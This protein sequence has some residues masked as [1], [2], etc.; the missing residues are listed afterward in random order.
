MSLKAAAEVEELREKVNQLEAAL[1]IAQAQVSNKPHPLLID[2][3]SAAQTTADSPTGPGTTAGDSNS[4][5][6]P[7]AAQSQDEEDV[8]DAFGTLTLGNRGE[9]RFFGQT[10]RTEAPERLKPFVDINIKLPRVT[11]ITVE[12]ACKELDVFCT[13]MTVGEEVLS[14][15]PPMEEALRLCEIYFECSKFLW[16]PLP[17][18]YVYTEIV[19]AI[20][21]QPKPGDDYCHV[22]RKHA[23]ALLFMIFALATLF[24]LNMPPYCSEAHEYLLFARICLRW[25]PPAYDTTL[26]AIQTLL[27]MAQYLEM[28][29]CE[30]AHTGSHKAW[31]EN[32]RAVSMGLSVDVSSCKWRLDDNAA[33]RRG[34]VFWQ[35]FALD[36]WLSF[37]FGRPPSISLTFVD[38]EIPQPEEV[39]AVDGSRWSTGYHVWTWQFTKLM[40]IITTEAFAAKSPT[41][42]KIMELDKRVRDFPDPPCLTEP[43]QPA[44]VAGQNDQV[45]RTM[46]VMGVTLMKEM[47]HM[48]LHRPY[49]SQALK[50][51]PEDPLRHKYGASVMV[52]YRSAW[53]I[54]NAVEQAYKVAPGLTARLSLHWSNTLACAIILSLIITRAPT[55][56]LATSALAELDKLCAL[57]E[58]AA[59]T[60]QIALNNIHVL[61]KLRSQSHAAINNLSPEDAAKVNAELDRLGGKT[62]LIQTIGER[63]ATC[64]HSF[65]GQNALYATM[66]LDPE[67]A[68]FL[69]SVFEAG[70]NPNGVLQ[71]VVAQEPPPPAEDHLSAQTQAF[72][73]GSAADFNFAFMDAS[74]GAGMGATGTG[75]TAGTGDFDWIN[76]FL[77]SAAG[78]AND[79][80]PN[81]AEVDANWQSLVDGLG[82]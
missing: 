20:Y 22:S 8:I 3:Y 55:S 30:A 32:R 41:Y 35:M 72:A 47:T 29:D 64:A 60:S 26:P 69:P 40:A 70:S 57:F 21:Q 58:D 43:A 73:P 44:T 23:M 9:A 50:D 56:A 65:R 53:R 74:M 12:E 51:A 1:A 15:I 45:T 10:S 61:R 31:M 11:R 75:A 16:Y 63:I 28:S 6:S 34:R 80:L 79:S 71:T 14:C 4:S 2:R 52:I 36:S 7:S 25:A 59:S 78:A 37:G 48:N 62:Q 68:M 17:R 49:L 67:K 77:N 81:A 54:I 76:G 66:V 27:Y 82:L 24:D 33:A 42:S 18:E 13:S 5:S 19:S 38:C 46:Q 39:T